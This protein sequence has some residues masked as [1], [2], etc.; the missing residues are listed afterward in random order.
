MAV[1]WRWDEGGM[2]QR[3]GRE[4]DRLKPERRLY[5]LLFL[6]HSR[7][8][9]SI[10]LFVSA[11]DTTKNHQASRTTRQKPLSGLLLRCLVSSVKENYI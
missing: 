5:L 3:W 10:G 9:K 11:P 7:K 6:P 2:G 4:E 8:L 1:G